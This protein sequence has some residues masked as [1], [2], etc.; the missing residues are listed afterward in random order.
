MRSPPNY[1]T[2]KQLLEQFPELKPSM[3]DYLVRE[4]IVSAVRRGRGINRLYDDRCFEQIRNYLQ[5]HETIEVQ[6][7]K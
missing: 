6:N 7:D 5:K 2:T 3:L 1:H 4:G